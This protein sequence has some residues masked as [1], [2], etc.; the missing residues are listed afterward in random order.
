[1]Q[2]HEPSKTIRLNLEGK[3]LGEQVDLLLQTK[4][5]SNGTSDSVDGVE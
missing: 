3:S 2:R 4:P 1:L 5:K